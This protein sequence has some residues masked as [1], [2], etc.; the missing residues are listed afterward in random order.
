MIRKAFGTQTL[1][2]SVWA[3]GRFLVART[4]R[5]LAGTRGAARGRAEYPVD[6]DR[7]SQG[8]EP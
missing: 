5:L 6:H 3:G 1:A 4:R 7:D 2:C 8:I